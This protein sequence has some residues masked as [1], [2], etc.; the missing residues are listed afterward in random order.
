MPACPN[1][2]DLPCPTPQTATRRGNKDEHG[3]T[4]KLYYSSAMAFLLPSLTPVSLTAVPCPCPA[5]LTPGWLGA[6]CTHQDD[7]RMSRSSP[8]VTEGVV[9]VVVAA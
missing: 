4:V 7:W 5:D 9:V 6:Q 2:R 8:G 1:T 3:T